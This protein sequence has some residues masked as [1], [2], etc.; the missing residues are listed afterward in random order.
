M[1]GEYE[2]AADETFARQGVESPV[3]YR[4]ERGDWVLAMAAAG[5]GYALMPETSANYPGVV[6]RPL[7]EP[8]IWRDIV[9]VT[10][11]GRA[12]SPGM[13]ALVREVMRM[14]WAGAPAPAQPLLAGGDLVAAT[15]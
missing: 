11:R 1:T 6:S 5:L 7:V 9:L 3:S 8:E 14:R 13:G 4:G 12:E 10:L 15:R 2:A